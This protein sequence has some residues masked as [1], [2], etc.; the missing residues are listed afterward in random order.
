MP[1]GNG[2]FFSF[3]ISTAIKALI[4][5]LNLITIYWNLFK[6]FVAYLQA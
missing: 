4:E 1:L 6:E 2:N 5:N 3:A